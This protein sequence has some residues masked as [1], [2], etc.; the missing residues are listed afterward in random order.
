MR[1][2]VGPRQSGKTTLAKE[3]LQSRGIE[4]LYYNWDKR[5][6]RSKYYEN[7]Y[8]YQSDFLGMDLKA[9]KWVCFDEI[10]KLPK[11][12]NILKDIY[13]TDRKSVRFIITGSARLDLMRK[14]GDSLTGRFFMFHLF[15]LSLKEF[16]GDVARA[17]N[18]FYKTE[19]DAHDFIEKC[20]SYDLYSQD[21]LETLLAFSGFPEPLTVGK[22]NF[23]LM[24]KNNYLDTILKEDL[25]DISGIKNLENLAKLI[26]VLPSKIGGPLSVN[27]LVPDL[28]ASYS[29]VKNYIHLLELGYL[30]FK[31]PPYTKKVVRAITKEKKYYFFDWTRVPELS[32]R[33]ENYV[34]FELFEMVN[35]WK[36]HGLGNFEL[37]FLRN[38]EGQ[39]TDF[40]I[41]KEQKPWMMVE[42]KLN[43]EQV[44]SHQ[45]RQS[46]KF[47]GIPIVQILHKDKIA[48]KTAKNVFVVSASRFFS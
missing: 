37:H 28:E 1:F 14:S 9:S 44:D 19:A 12:K 30:I 23:L 21:K 16:N 34:A 20:F 45:I 22:E 40:L 43:D 32:R 8:F 15:P 6:I 5:D 41:T 48:K 25:R 36:D 17:N 29:A 18:K 33:F 11:W 42:V 35:F 47:G 31:I 38:R 27:S 2:V 13:D 26:T 3:F 39:E 7:A 24:W 46:E 10:H 4:K